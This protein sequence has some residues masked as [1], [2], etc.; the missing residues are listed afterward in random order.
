MK[1]RYKKQTETLHFSIAIVKNTS[2]SNGFTCLAQA[3]L[4]VLYA[5]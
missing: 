2:N 1:Y 3:F 5:E 4:V